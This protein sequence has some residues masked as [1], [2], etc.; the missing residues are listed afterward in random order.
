MA[1]SGIVRKG[2]PVKEMSVDMNGVLVLSIELKDNR[3]G[4][5]PDRCISL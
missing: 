3:R 1:T 2:E 4:L 5:S